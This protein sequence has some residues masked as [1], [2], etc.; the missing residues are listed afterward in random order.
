MGNK[1][2]FDLWSA[3]IGLLAGVLGAVLFGRFRQP[4]FN[5]WQRLLGQAHELRRRMSA[6]VEGRYREE[7]AQYAQDRHLGVGAAQLEEIFKTLDDTGK[8]QGLP[9]SRSN[10]SLT[11]G[12][13]LLL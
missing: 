12:R 2:Q 3:L 8:S 13:P 5:L 11:G 1:W 9:L 6:G 10:H 4:A 7:V